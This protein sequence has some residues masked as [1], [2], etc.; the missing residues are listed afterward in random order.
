M[1]RQIVARQQGDDYQARWFWLQ[2]CALLDEFSKVERVVH[3]D[4]ALKSFDDVAVYYLPGYTDE[5]GNPLNAKFYQVKFHVTSA[6]ALTAESLC[7]P[8]FIGATT[9]S[10][11]QRIKNAHDHC[12][13][14][15]LN[16][17]IVFYTPWSVHPNDELAKVHSMSDG[18]IRWNTLSGAT[19]GSK[20]GKIRKQWREH[21]GI[22]SD[23][24]LRQIL[25]NVQIK[26]GP[27]L[28]DLATELNWRL[29]AV[30]LK[31]VEESTLIH[32]YDEL[33]RKML[34]ASLNELTAKSL[35]KICGQEGLLLET[36]SSPATATALGIR[37]F[38]RWAEDLQN[39]TQA[40]F[41]LSHHF[42]GRGIKN[43][44]DWNTEIPNSLAIFMKQQFVRGGSYRLHLDT[45]SSIAYLAGYLLPEKMGINVEVVQ[46]SGRGASVWSFDKGHE[47]TSDS[48]EFV[49]EKCHQ[50]ASES[51]LAIGLTLDIKNDVVSY[52]REYLPSVGRLVMALPVG[53]PASSGVRDGAHAAELANQLIQYLRS[54]GIGLSVESS[55]HIFFAA[56]NGFVFCLARKM[57]SVPYWKLYEYDFGSG[58]VG[59]YSPSIM[60]S[61]RS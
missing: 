5:K 46:H 21:L 47:T 50:G 2:A 42:E 54:N 55:V 8:A 11:L 29:K 38:L 15:G 7:D 30:G 43:P 20:L 17:R 14:N 58:I 19:E 22:H 1:A 33:T 3:E 28:D 51:A 40:M 31:P 23:D 9:F 35:R 4:V 32:P 53:G 26:R 16:Y 37:S 34:Q 27:T 10:L 39:Q 52:I 49:Q 36:S 48:W 41:C 25:A 12:C 13:S 45:H 60:N 61:N 56:P 6:G 18:G 59:A 24:E 57:Q 44:A